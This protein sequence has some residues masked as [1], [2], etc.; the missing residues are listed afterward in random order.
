MTR[1]QPD[2]VY[3]DSDEDCYW[4]EMTNGFTDESYYQPIGMNGGVG[5]NLDPSRIEASAWG[6]SGWGGWTGVA[7]MARFFSTVGSGPRGVEIEFSSWLFG[8]LSVFGS[9]TSAMKVE[10]VVWNVNTDAEVSRTFIEIERGRVGNIILDQL[11]EKTIQTQLYPSTSYGLIT[12]LQADIDIVGV[13]NATS[14]WGPQDGDDSG[15]DVSNM[16]YE[17]IK[18]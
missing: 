9:S 11:I 2:T 3:L 14:D 10:A 17:L 15:E 8:G 5:Y 12:R 4:S 1:Y 13:G 18:L 6:F 7:E 16:T